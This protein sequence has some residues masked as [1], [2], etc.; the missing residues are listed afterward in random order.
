MQRCQLPS[1][2]CFLPY[3]PSQ[4]SKHCLGG[5]NWFCYLLHT[6]E[7]TKAQVLPTCAF[8]SLPHTPIPQPSQIPTPSSL[9][10]DCMVTGTC[11]S[12]CSGIQSFN[13]LAPFYLGRDWPLEAKLL[14][15]PLTVLFLSPSAAEIVYMLGLSWV[16]VPDLR[17][18]LFTCCS[19]KAFRVRGL[20]WT[21]LVVSI[22][23]LVLNHLLIWAAHQS[24]GILSS[25]WWSA[26]KE[27]AHTPSTGH[28]RVGL[29]S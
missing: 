29:V 24:I 16:L 1:V 22:F 7:E 21:F 2:H 9:R 3:F 28:M 10:M 15:S 25:V 4:F 5:S 13:F 12:H 26:H 8:P 23:N 11:T 14:V 20:G 17:S 6:G 27:A 19:G 18:G